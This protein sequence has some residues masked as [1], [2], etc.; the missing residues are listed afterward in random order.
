MDRPCVR[1]I[2]CWSHF[3]RRIIDRHLCH[4]IS[5]RLDHSAYRSIWTQSEQYNTYSNR[6]YHHYGGLRC[7]RIYGPNISTSKMQV[8]DT[9]YCEK[10]GKY[11]KKY[12]SI[13]YPLTNVPLFC[14]YLQKKQADSFA[15]F[16]NSISTGKSREGYCRVH[17][18]KLSSSRIY[19]GYME[20]T[21]DVSLA[22]MKNEAEQTLEKSW[23]ACSVKAEPSEINTLMKALKIKR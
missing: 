16:A 12:S 14:Q 9:K 23:I 4:W 1:D 21:V 22:Y 5:D 19:E 3:F 6:L 18:Y 8:D 15:E 11:L 2:F 20:I 7:F 10:N 17:L 13:E